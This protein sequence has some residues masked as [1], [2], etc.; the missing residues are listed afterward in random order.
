MK[1]TGKTGIS[2]ILEKSRESC[3]SNVEKVYVNPAGGLQGW[4]IIHFYLGKK[5]YMWGVI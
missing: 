4:E 1:N 2:I 5:T 3:Q